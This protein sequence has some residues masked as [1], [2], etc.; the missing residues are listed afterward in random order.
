MEIAVKQIINGKHFYGIYNRLPRRCWSD[1]S[2]YLFFSTTQRNNIVSYILNISKQLE[3][4]R[5]NLIN[6]FSTLIFLLCKIAHQKKINF[7]YRNR[8]YY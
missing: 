4:Y 3:Y 5:Y 8:R 6:I 7:I 1:D 2:Q